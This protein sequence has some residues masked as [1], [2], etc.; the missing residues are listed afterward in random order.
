SVVRNEF[1]A[2]WR[3][4]VAQS[5]DPRNDV[6]SEALHE[7][8]ARRVAVLMRVQRP[9]EAEVA[10]AGARS[11]HVR[12]H[13]EVTVELTAE[14]LVRALERS[15][16]AR[17]RT[18]RARGFFERCRAAA[19]DRHLLVGRGVRRAQLSEGANRPV[20]VV[21]PAIVHRRYHE[22]FVGVELQQ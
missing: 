14:A 9:E 4:R 16:H 8:A 7:G 3:W 5:L 21:A 17:L 12:G 6:W 19:P 13:G 10:D 2:E 1:A 22:P 15:V 20:A 11:E 18:E